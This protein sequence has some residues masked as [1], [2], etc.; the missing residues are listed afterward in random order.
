MY[1]YANIILIS[2]L[3]INYT[4]AFRDGNMLNF[5]LMKYIFVLCLFGSNGIIASYIL[6]NSY[7]IV[8]WR[9]FIAAT[10][11][12][13]VFLLSRQ[14][15]TFLHL[16][17]DAFFLCLGGFSLGLS[18]IFLFEAYLHIGVSVGTLLYYC[19]PVIVMVLAPLIFKE[20]LTSTKLMG[21]TIVLAGMVILNSEAFIEGEMS[22]GILFGLLA[23]VMYS[24]MVIF[25][26]KGQ[27]IQ[28]LE[29]TTIQLI[30]AFSLVAIYTI[31]KGGF[32]VAMSEESILPIFILG[33]V[34]TGIGCYMYFTS[35]GKLP[36]QTVSILGYLEPLSALVFSAI[37]LGENLSLLQLIGAACIL[38]GAALGE[39][40]KE[41]KAVMLKERYK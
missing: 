29:N 9:T 2:N 38:G 15:F 18:W 4:K 26:K 30:A 19:G 37:L 6:L 20:R 32:P 27:A 8:F 22:V 31:V 40:Y 34:N 5:N 21:F 12:L 36:V 11:L 33:L 16:R 35:I 13:G 10:F 1:C 41:E 24:T 39:L 3:H 14:K 25:N 28:G 23:A 17:K 7:E